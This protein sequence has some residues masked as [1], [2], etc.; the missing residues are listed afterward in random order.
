MRMNN[1]D[2]EI[3]DVAYEIGLDAAKEMRKDKKLIPLVLGAICIIVVV[4][5]FTMIFPLIDFSKVVGHAVGESR[6]KK[7]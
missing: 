2:Q 6:K 1:D 5:F 4:F 3:T 7:V